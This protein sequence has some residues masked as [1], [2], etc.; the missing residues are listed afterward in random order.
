MKLSGRSDSSVA[1]GKE[2]RIDMPARP[3]QPDC[4]TGSND[5]EVTGT[6]DAAIG[7]DEALTTNEAFWDRE[8]DDIF[9][10]LL[11]AG[12]SLERVVDEGRNRAPDSKAGIGSWTHESAYIGGYFVVV[13]RKP[14]SCS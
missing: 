6:A 14:R 4:A 10:G 13:A 7:K 9:N 2:V 12:L 5:D 1:L 3:Y 8:M 11:D